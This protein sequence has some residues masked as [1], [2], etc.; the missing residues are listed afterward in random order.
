[1]R[2][3]K[4]CCSSTL[5]GT[6]NGYVRI[7]CGFIR[8]ITLRINPSLPAASGACK[9]ISNDCLSSTNN[10]Y[11]SSCSF[12]TVSA[13]NA[14][15]ASLSLNGPL[16]LVSNFPKSTL[17]PG[18]TRYSFAKSIISCFRYRR[19]SKRSCRYLY[20]H[21]NEVDNVPTKQIGGRRGDSGVQ[22]PGK[23]GEKRSTWHQA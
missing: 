12:S 6:L 20:P 5:L 1:M 15:A 21:Q 7:P 14:L 22:P 16:V 2:H 19:V 23:H 13:V 11:C 18:L 10:R 9:T 8:P 17:S 3:K 4:S